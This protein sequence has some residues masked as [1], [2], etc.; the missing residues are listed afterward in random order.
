MLN[1]TMACLSACLVQ[2]NWNNHIDSCLLKSKKS[3]AKVKR[4]KLSNYACVKLRTREQGKVKRNK[5][6]NY[7]CLKLRTRYSHYRCGSSNCIYKLFIF[8][9]NTDPPSTNG[10]LYK[11]LHNL[12]T[13]PPW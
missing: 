4:N 13:S 5:L 8:L 3:K 9:A 12:P 1:F 7:A 10:R 2:T 6:S 11:G